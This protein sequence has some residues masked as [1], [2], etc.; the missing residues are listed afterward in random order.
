MTARTLTIMGMALALAGA[1]G[2]KQTSDGGTGA[3]GGSGA[4]DGGAGTGGTN[5][6][7]TGGATSC[8]M[9]VA[10]V[11]EGESCTP[12]GCCQCSYACVAGKWQMAACPGCLQ[13]GCPEVQP[14]DGTACDECL[15]PVGVQCSYGQCPG[16][17][18][19]A[20]CDGA[21]WSVE[22]APCPPKVLCGSD[23]GAPA[24]PSGDLCVHPGGLGDTP[25]CAQNPCS[26]GQP[27]SC[28][29]AGAL[30]TYGYCSNAT[31]SAVYCECP[32]C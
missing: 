32:N 15:H 18:S 24:C 2:G 16:G 25:Y 10:C 3:S 11:T 26:P 13:P 9:G 12:P 4:T 27:V 21:T 14:S 8:A 7:G 6:G 30:C 17:V 5:T 19:V 28:G 29:C 23:P 22:A 1:C 31:P 20:K